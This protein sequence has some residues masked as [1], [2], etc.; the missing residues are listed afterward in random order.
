MK[1]DKA[2]RSWFWVLLPVLGAV[3]AACGD[4]SETPVTDAAILG[5]HSD[6]VTY[7]MVMY[8]TT[9]GVRTGRIEADSA[10]YFEDSTV[11]HMQGIEMD[12]YT[13]LGEVRATVTAERGRYD[14]SSQ[15]MHAL[16]NVVLTLPADGRQVESPEL[17]YDP[18]SEHIW[19]D[20]ASTYRHDGQVTRGTCFRSDLSFRNYEV[21][22]I[23]GSADI[24][25]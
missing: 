25:G 16:G 4:A 23:R 19:S 11:V 7:N 10:Y 20:S 9:D 17:Y 24:G 1:I 22:N 2:S 13:D 14:E 18:T 5:M 8:F 15:Q 6:I 3:A 21:C 12:V